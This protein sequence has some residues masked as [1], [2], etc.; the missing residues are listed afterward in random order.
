[1]DRGKRQILERQIEVSL[2]LQIIGCFEGFVII[3]QEIVTWGGWVFQIK[4]AA[5]CYQYAIVYWAF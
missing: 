4:G 1:M 5:F 3:C 2:Y